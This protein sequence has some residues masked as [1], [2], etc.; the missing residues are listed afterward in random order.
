[1]SSSLVLRDARSNAKFG[2]AVNARV[3]LANICIQRAGRCRKPIGLV[4]T[5]GMPA[6]IGNIS[7]KTKPMS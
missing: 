7:P 4:S 1:M 2:A 5:A 3:L 6:R